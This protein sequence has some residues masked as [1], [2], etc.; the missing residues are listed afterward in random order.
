VANAM[1]PWLEVA[2]VDS[3]RGQWRTWGSVF[4]RIGTSGPK[5]DS[6]N[7][8]YDMHGVMAAADY[9]VVDGT[10]LGVAASRLE[11]ETF[12]AV[13]A[14]KS[15]LSTNSIGFY[16]SQASAQWRAGAGLSVSDGKLKSNRI[17]TI[18]AQTATLAA[19]ANTGSESAFV[20]TS[21]VLGTETWLVKP[22]ASLT[23]VRAKVGAYDE[24]SATGLAV[25]RST[26]SSLRGDVGLRAIA[27]PGP[28]HISLAA[29]WS[30]NFKDNDR[31]TSARLSGLAGSDF[32]IVGKPEKRGWL[33]TQA[34]VNIEVMPGMMAR[35]G[36]SGILND[37]LGGHTAT[38]GLSYRW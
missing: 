12:F 26:A 14:A 31:M 6:R 5:T 21:Y 30:Q 23:Y 18:G 28:V 37:R 16:V 8:D 34:G 7:F 11:G 25:T 36:W 3:P 17:Q 29:F 24:A 35:L 19:R 4:G 10:R 22:T 32:T 1:S 27:K 15:N 33:N 38:A 9:A 20:Q 13:N 2:P